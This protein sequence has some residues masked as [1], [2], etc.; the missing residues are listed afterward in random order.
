MG[1][2]KEV[3]ELIRSV[4]DGDV[5][6]VDLSLMVAPSTAFDIIENVLGLEQTSDLDTNGWQ[7]DFWQH[8]EDSEGK[9]FVLSGSGYYGELEFKKDTDNGKK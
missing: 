4:I 7:W 1:S 3:E 5:D 6:T 8:Y 2:F 9:K